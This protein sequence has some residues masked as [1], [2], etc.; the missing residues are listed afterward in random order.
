MRFIQLELMQD[1][2]KREEEKRKREEEDDGIHKGV[3]LY[4]GAK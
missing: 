4:D 2:L 3:S 1:Y